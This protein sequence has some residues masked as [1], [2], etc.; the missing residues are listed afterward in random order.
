M[1]EKAI[2]LKEYLQPLLKAAV[3]NVAECSY[4]RA[5]NGRERV[6]IRMAF[7]DDRIAI[8][9]IDVTGD[10]LLSMAAHFIRVMQFK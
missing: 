4:Q 10:S 1:D 3:G 8:C 7:A 6:S 5:E 2:F 9:N